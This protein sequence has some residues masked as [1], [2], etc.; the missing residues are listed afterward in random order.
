MKMSNKKYIA[1]YKCL[2]PGLVED[3][4]EG[5]F[6]YVKMMKKHGVSSGTIRR[7]K[8]AMGKPD[9]GFYAEGE[10]CDL[11]YH[12]CEKWRSWC[13]ANVRHWRTLNKG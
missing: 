11:D 9:G 3:I 4:E 12:Q 13:E 6:S 2:I 8:V 10:W 7:L 1:K 5:K